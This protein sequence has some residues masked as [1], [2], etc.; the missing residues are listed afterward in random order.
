MSVYQ[1]V[2]ELAA[3]CPVFLPLSRLMEMKPDVARFEQVA[4]DTS[5]A[6]SIDKLIGGGFV[7]KNP[8]PI[9]LKKF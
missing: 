5:L 7:I 8:P 6:L 9:G 1:Q 4:R 2:S 3:P